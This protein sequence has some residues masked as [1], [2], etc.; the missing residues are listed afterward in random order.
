MRT[1]LLIPALVLLTT[2]TTSS[3]ALQALGNSPCAIQCGNVLES[4]TGADIACND[5][6]FGSTPGSVFKT[7]VSCQLSSKY[8][9]P[10]NKQ[11]D[12]QWGLYN[13]RYAMSWCLFGYPNN[14]AAPDTPCKTSF[15]CGPLENSFEF[16]SLSP[17]AGA[18]SYCGLFS[19]DRVTSCNNCLKVQQNQLFWVNYAIA[20]QAACLQQPISGN[21]ISLK[22]DI[23]SKTM[24]NITVP[25]NSANSTFTGNATGG[26]NLGAKVGISVGAILFALGLTGFCIV[27]NGKRRRRRIL[28]KHQRDTGYAQWQAQ[29]EV[30]QAQ[31]QHQ[32][33]IEPDSG[34]SGGF[35][36]SPQSTR[37]LVNSRPWV[38]GQREEES[39]L[40]AV[41]EKVYFSP[42]SSQYSSPVSAQDQPHVAGR[43]WPVDRKGS[44]GGTSAMGFQS[45]R[46]RKEKERERDREDAGFE[47]QNVAPV[48]MHP[49]NGR[50]QPVS[51]TEQPRQL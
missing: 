34:I 44:L 36:D 30:A 25:L 5:G 15:A 47:M 2:F 37:P 8:V 21:L 35:F 12:L 14:T 7:C 46:E 11:T 19:L 29:Q 43:E 28:Q 26:L 31:H 4:T 41:G 39:P 22:G 45:H 48:L 23:F 50:G 9:D 13:L 51:P 20:L 16:D 24:V 10:T 1:S 38:P 32:T 27:W 42:Y 33:P 40:S 3:T 49:G 18:F 17:K 6:D